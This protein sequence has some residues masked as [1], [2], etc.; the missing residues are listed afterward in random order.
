MEQFL[1]II[2]IALISFFVNRA[3]EQKKRAA[4]R[5]QPTK[6]NN[7]PTQSRQG[8]SWMPPV[9]RPSLEK[10]NPVQTER[11]RSLREAAEIL[12]SQMQPQLEE[13]KAESESKIEELQREAAVYEKKAREFQQKAEAVKKLKAADPQ[14]E[15]FFQKDDIVKGIIMSEV[16]G[17][18]RAKRRYGR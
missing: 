2:I 3:S 17:P 4:N 13:K 18:P 12:L 9:D 15:S 1:P 7:R 8:E 5:E 11:P 16:L 6:P 14:M 10:P